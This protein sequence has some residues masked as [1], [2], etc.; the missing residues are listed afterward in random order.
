M[1]SAPVDRDR[2]DVTAAAVTTTG[3]IGTFRRMI[4]GN[5]C[6][7]PSRAIGYHRLPRLTASRIVF[8]N[9]GRT[10]GPAGGLNAILAYA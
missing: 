1:P 5:G 6:R 8:A 3:G 2:A 9:V 4:G 10:T 7:R